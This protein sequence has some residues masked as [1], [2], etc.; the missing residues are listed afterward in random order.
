MPDFNVN[1]NDLAMEMRFGTYV[2]TWGRS[3]KYTS[4]WVYFIMTSWRE[5]EFALS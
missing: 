3:L 4:S 2:T 1:S 5:Y